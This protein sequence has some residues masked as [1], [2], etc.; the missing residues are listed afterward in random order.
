MKLPEAKYAERMAKSKQIKFYGLEHTLSAGDGDIWD[1]RNLTSD[2]A[3]VL[4]VRDRRWRIRKLE[5]P[6]GLYS[7]GKLIWVDGTGFYYD[8]ALKGEVSEGQKHFAALGPNVIILPD[9]KYYNTETDT[10]GAL[11]AG[12]EG[13]AL[14]FGNGTLYGEEAAA[15]ALTAEG[16]A[17]AERF[18][19]GDAVTIS[20]CKTHPEN[21]KTAIVREIDGDTMFFYEYAFTLEGEEAYTEEGELTVARTVPDLQYLC[22]NENRL[23]GCDGRTVY[24]S[25]LGDPFNWNVYDGLETDAWTITPEIG[26]AHV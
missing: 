15:N 25:K 21:N 6:G 20:G 8:G 3:P 11:E 18:R 1:M 5:K 7:W 16:A 22:E 12:W 4:A 24:A 23:W 19:A 14:R 9:K 10:F 26:R 2:H 17:W 13:R